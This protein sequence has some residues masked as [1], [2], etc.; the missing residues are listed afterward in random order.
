MLNDIDCTSGQVRVRHGKGDKERYVPFGRNAKR[1]LW[2]YIQRE[3]RFADGAEPLFLSDRGPSAAA[4]ALTARGMTHII[5]RLG[6]RAKL[7]A[8]VRCSPHTYR[9]I[10]VVMSLRNGAN[11]FSLKLWLGHESLVMV[12]RYLALSNADSLAAH[13]LSSPADRLKE[14]GR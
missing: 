13:R 14:K 12:N 2:N 3:R 5:A 9:H 1:A 7:P 8:T 6:K 4:N 11:I 10:F